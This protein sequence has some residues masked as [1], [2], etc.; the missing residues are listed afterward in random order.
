M[1][2]IEERAG[3]F[4]EANK[5]ENREEC[6]LLSS[7]PVAIERREEMGGGSLKKSWL[8]PFRQ[9]L[10]IAESSQAGVWQGIQGSKLFF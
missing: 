10:W 8:S 1:K 7:A 3:G 2:P 9:H 6:T 4:E 5:L